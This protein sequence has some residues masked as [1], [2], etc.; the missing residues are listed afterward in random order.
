MDFPPVLRVTMATLNVKPMLAWLPLIF[1]SNRLSRL[2][3]CLDKME[4][5]LCKRFK[6]KVPVSGHK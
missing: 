5:Y 2:N 3:Q 6:V 4:L 1:Y